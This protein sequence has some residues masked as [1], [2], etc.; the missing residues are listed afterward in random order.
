[1]E[2]RQRRYE[3]CETYL[4]TH[5]SYW[6]GDEMVGG[7]RQDANPMRHYLRQTDAHRRAI[8]LFNRCFFVV[9]DLLVHTS[10]VLRTTPGAHT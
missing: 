3:Y 9:S 2:V 6:T 7:M 5:V 4:L 10:L 1:M 8:Y